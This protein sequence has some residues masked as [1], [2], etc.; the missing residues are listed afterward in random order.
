[1]SLP[2]IVPIGAFIGLNGDI[3]A[4]GASQKKGIDLAV[5]EINLSDYLGKDIDLKV[6]IE[7]SGA[8]RAIWFDSGRDCGGGG[9]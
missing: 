4:Y 5:K 1:M 2:S 6:I 7:D 8:S 3:A 9:K